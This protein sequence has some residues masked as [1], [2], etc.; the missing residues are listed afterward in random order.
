MALTQKF[1]STACA[2]TTG[3]PTLWTLTSIVILMGRR[4]GMEGVGDGQ[5]PVN[6]TGGDITNLVL[7]QAVKV[8]AV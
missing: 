5:T 7:Q 2:M 6:S 8:T 1:P 4:L 3:V